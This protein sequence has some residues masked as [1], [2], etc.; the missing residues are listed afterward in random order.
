[1]WEFIGKLAAITVA[2]N[3]TL[4]WLIVILTGARKSNQ[5]WP[6]RENL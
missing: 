6:D 3:I 2:V 5:P 1:M 4:T